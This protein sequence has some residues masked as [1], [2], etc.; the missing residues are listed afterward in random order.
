MDLRG[1]EVPGTIGNKKSLMDSRKADVIKNTPSI[2]AKCWAVYDVNKMSF[3]HGKREYYKRECASLTKI[4]TCYV[5]LELSRQWKLNIKKTEI[6]VSAI[7][8]DI[9]GTVAHLETGDV[10]TIE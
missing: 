10:L 8:S 4:M 1:P 9:R 5:V 7:A 3:I 2:S 6:M